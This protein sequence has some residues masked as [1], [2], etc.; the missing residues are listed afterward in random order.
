M[1]QFSLFLMEYQV[2]NLEILLSTLSKQ[3]ETLF[4]DIFSKHCKNLKNVLLVGD[5]NINF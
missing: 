1:M 4:K 2:I 3:C 5:F